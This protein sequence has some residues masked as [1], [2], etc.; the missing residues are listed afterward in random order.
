MF[1]HRRRAGA[2]RPH[3]RSRADLPPPLSAAAQVAAN[4]T[5]AEEMLATLCLLNA[6][7]TA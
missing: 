7:A 6:T 3:F 4:V 5:M 1:L 2:G